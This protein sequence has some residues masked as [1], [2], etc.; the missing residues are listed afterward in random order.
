VRWLE[1]NRAQ[2][3]SVGTAPEAATALQ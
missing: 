3:T 2:Y 1:D